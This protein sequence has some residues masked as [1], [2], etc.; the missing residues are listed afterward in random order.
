MALHQW[1]VDI[2]AFADRLAVVQS[3]QNREEA[4][5]LLQQAGNGV[6]IFGTAMTA[7]AF[8][9]GLGFA[10]SFDGG[11]DLVL[12]CLRQVGES[13]AVGGVLGLE[14][15][16]WCGPVTVDEVAKGRALID[17]PGQR[18]SCAFGGGAVIHGF[19]D[20]FNGHVS[21]PYEVIL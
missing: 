5:V 1:D 11:I 2:T 3:F 17:N 16:A 13:L 18:I 9:F 14:V 4:A 12:R 21:S 20:L 10:R 15:L 8:P 19:E 7:Q 6:E